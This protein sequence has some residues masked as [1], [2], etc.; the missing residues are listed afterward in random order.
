MATRKNK[1]NDRTVAQQPRLLPPLPRRQHLRT[2][3]LGGGI[4]G[5]LVVEELRRHRQLGYQPVGFLDDDKRKRYRRIDGLPVLGSLA[6]LPVLAKRHRIQLVLLAIPSASGALHR[7]ITRLVQSAGVE[8]RVLPG[9]Y[10]VLQHDTAAGIARPVNLE[11][12][13][14]RAPIAFDVDRMRQMLTGK[15]VLITGAAGSIGQEL[16]RQLAPFEPRE[17]LLIDH[18]ENNLYDTYLA[19]HSEFPSLSLQ[20]FVADIR[21]RRRIRDILQTRR[22]DVLYHAAAYKHVPIME[23]N[24]LEAIKTNVL[25]SAVLVEEAAR[26]GIRRFVLIST[27]KAVNP[28]SVMGACKR[29]A[30]LIVQSAAAR[31]PSTAFLVVRFGNVVR[32]RGNVFERFAQQIAKGGP[33]TLTHPQMRRYFMTREEATQ[34]VMQASVLGRGG[35]LF[36]LDMGAQVKVSTMAYQMIRLA[37]LRPGVDVPIVWI[38][39]RPGEKLKE[40]LLTPREQARSVKFQRIRKIESPALPWRTV[41]TALRA[42]AQ[43][44]ASEDPIRGKNLLHRYVANYQEPGHERASRSSRRT[45]R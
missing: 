2:L 11:D 14:R 43:A 7:R 9:L 33:V 42:F 44:A 5:R 28:S 25:G 45:A 31:F 17:L 15:T 34:L 4:A 36:V 35:E 3:I 23:F 29:C 18:E 38:G 39:L 21:D 8:L 40:E 41:A 30:E 1:N 37:G 22:P 24:A 6:Q 16:C 13:F 12:F 27:D 20:V 10:E 26:A 32:S 19:L